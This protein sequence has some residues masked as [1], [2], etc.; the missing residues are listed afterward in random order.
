V[1]ETVG[2]LEGADVGDELGPLVGAR[3]DLLGW[4][5][6]VRVGVGVGTGL[7]RPPQPQVFTRQSPTLLIS[8]FG[9]SKPISD[10]LYIPLYSSFSSPKR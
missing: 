3:G 7:I 6:G 1:G 10:T 9:S 2:E 4:D 8:A 5:V